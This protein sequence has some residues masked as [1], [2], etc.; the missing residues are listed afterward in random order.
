MA[1]GDKSPTERAAEAYGRSGSIV[2]PELLD[3]M[4]ADRLDTL[5]FPLAVVD[6]ALAV[7][8][9][10][11]AALGY[12]D[13]PTAAEVNEA[14]RT[15]DVTTPAGDHVRLHLADVHSLPTLLG[16]SDRE[17]VAEHFRRHHEDRGLAHHVAALSWTR[18]GVEEVIA[19]WAET[20]FPREQFDRYYR[21]HLA[22]GVT[23]PA[24]SR[25]ADPDGA[26][27]GDRIYSPEDVITSTDGASVTVGAL[28]ALAER[29]NPIQT[30]EHD[31]LRLHLV[32]EHCNVAGAG[33]S[34]EEALDYH[35]HEH[36]S[37][38][39]GLRIH[40]DA[41]RA[42]SQ[43]RLDRA[44]ADVDDDLERLG[45]TAGTLEVIGRLRASGTPTWEVAG[46]G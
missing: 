27:N 32:A 46:D 37:P 33:L 21:E 11:R 18:H 29:H 14:M 12:T 36:H 9:A 45:Y 6:H 24:S 4:R 23:E 26:V 8:A 20:G 16:L 22:R 44:L 2:P 34:D 1:A 31:P 13:S 41:S 25:P 35:H 40:D 3:A 5:D 42:W 15:A 28:V 7:T 10:L 38:A 19:G 43:P 17:A 30:P 39:G